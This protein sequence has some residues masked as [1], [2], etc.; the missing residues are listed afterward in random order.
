MVRPQGQS[1]AQVNGKAL[2]DKIIGGLELGRF[3]PELD[4][5]LLVCAT[6]TN[7]RDEMDR[8]AQAFAA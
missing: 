7:R 1:G 6:E 2:D 4:G 5:A 8:F 3:Y